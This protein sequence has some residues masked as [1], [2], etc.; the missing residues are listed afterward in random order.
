MCKLHEDFL[1]LVE[2]CWI[3]AL[4]GMIGPLTN[5]FMDDEIWHVIHNE[6]GDKAPGPDGFNMTFFKVY[7][8]FLKKDM[9][10]AL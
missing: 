5:A 2:K 1:P 4:Q 6:E 10:K 7:W 8:N 9:A 3:Q